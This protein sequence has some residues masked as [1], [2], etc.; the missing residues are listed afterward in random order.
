V[1]ISGPVT[2]RRLVAEP[3]LIHQGYTRCQ[4]DDL[5]VSP[6]VFCEAVGAPSSAALEIIEIFC[7]EDAARGLGPRTT[8]GIPIPNL[9]ATKGVSNSLKEIY[10][11]DFDV[12]FP[13]LTFYEEQLQSSLSYVLPTV[14][15]SETIELFTASVR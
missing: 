12:E 4:L 10:I 7:C 6:Y 11:G 15:E 13:C 9:N 5:L 8:L 1:E 2:T 3:G 14:P